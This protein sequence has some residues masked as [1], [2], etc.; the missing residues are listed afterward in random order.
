[1][2]KTRKAVTPTPTKLPLPR[3][4][5]RRIALK[6]G[7]SDK[8]LYATLNGSRPGHDARVQKAVSEARKSAEALANV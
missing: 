6:H 2:K 5:V 4:S 7:I 1:M 8:T 3:F